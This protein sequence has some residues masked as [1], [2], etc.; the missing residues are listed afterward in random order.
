MY[1]KK[2]REKTDDP[3][4]RIYVNKKEKRITVKIKPRCYLEFLTVEKMKLLENTKK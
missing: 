1:L 2:H 3:S 4:I